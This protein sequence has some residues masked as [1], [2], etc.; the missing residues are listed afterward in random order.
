MDNSRCVILVPAAH[1]IEPHCEL[2]L[3]QLEGMGH[4]VRRLHGF[5][6]IDL[7]R[8]RLAADALAE[9]FEELMWIDSDMAFEPRSVGQLRAHGLPLVCGLYPKKI[10]KALTAQLL[11]GTREIVFG[12]GGG[13]VEILY[14]ATGFLYTRRQVYLD[15]QQKLNLPLCNQRTGRPIVPYFLP[16]VVGAGDDCTY[17]GE[18]FS[19]CERA[20]RCGHRIFAD[21]TIRLQHIGI[22]GYSWEDLAAGLPHAATVRV[23]L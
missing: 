10:E 19:F 9:G 7:A 23:Q 14:A 1:A 17:L 18:D 21:T 3:R 5:S 15:V 12:Q 8:N 2:T 22:Y 11:P 6:Q 13:V 4:P 16:M 20:R